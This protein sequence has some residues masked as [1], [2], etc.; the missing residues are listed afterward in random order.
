MEAPR[1]ATL[2][3]KRLIGMNIRMSLAENKT[4]T[5]W[6]QLMPRRH[7]IDS[8]S[9]NK[10]SIQVYDPGFDFNSFNAETVFTKWGAFEASAR[11]SVPE[12]MEEFILEGGLY[13][14]FLHKGEQTEFHRTM[15]YIYGEWIQSSGYRLDSRAQFELMD[16]RYL[17][18][19]NENSQ[20]EVWIPIRCS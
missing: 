3:A 14:I 20:E 1:I 19:L 16:E 4:H 12:S 17:G 18:P 7:E 5:L 13:A 8:S 9:N 15:A 2:E 6:S 11:S 10:Y